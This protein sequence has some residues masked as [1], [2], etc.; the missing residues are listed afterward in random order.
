MK[1]YATTDENKMSN[2]I[3]G[4]GGVTLGTCTNSLE[5]VCP[6]YICTGFDGFK[7]DP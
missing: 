3:H 7:L 2:P 5:T 6:S 1:E 4:W